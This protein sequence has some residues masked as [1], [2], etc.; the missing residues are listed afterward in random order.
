MVDTNADGVLL[1]V[2]YDRLLKPGREK[3]SEVYTQIDKDINDAF[4]LLT[5][6][7]NS[8]YVTKYVARAFQARVA[9]FNGDWNAAKTAALDVVNNGGDTLAT[10]ANLFNYWK[11]PAPVSNKP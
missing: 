11:N 10:A 2:S 3:V 7:K 6:T 5:A 8:S 4:G 1:V 9:L